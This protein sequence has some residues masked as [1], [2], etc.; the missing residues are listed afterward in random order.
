MSGPFINN[1]FPPVV[2]TEPIIRRGKLSF[3]IGV[4]RSGKSTYCTRWAQYLEGA[5]AV[6]TNYPRAIVCADSLRLALTGQRYNK[7]TEPM[8]WAIK[9]YMVEALL[10]RGHD[11]IV[12]GTHTTKMSILKNLEHDVNA[13]YVVVDTPKEE[14]LRR[15]VLTGQDDL[16]P[17]IHRTHGQLRKMLDYGVDK[18]IEEIRQEVKARW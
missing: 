12:D 5:D 10:D 8:V 11:V 16:V 13:T 15:A 2:A 9:D 17:V 14:C 7:K 1:Q 4:Q 3:V 6:P 18:M